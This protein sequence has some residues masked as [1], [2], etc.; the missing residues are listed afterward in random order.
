MRTIHLINDLTCVGG[1]AITVPQF[2]NALVDADL[3]VEL[4]SIARGPVDSSEFRFRYREFPSSNVLRQLNISGPLHDALRAA[5]RESLV[6]H[7]HGLWSM[8]SIYPT[9]VARRQK[10]I[11]TVMAPHGALAPFAFRWRWWRKAPFWWAVQKKALRSFDALHSTGPGETRDLRQ[12]GLKQP[13]IVVPNVVPIP[14]KWRD[15]P[16][17][18][19]PRRAMFLGRLHPIKG[20]DTL[21]KAW[22]LVQ[23]RFP[24]W[25]LELVGPEDLK[26]YRLLLSQL[27]GELG[28]QR[29]IF[30]GPALNG[31]RDAAYNRAD[32]FVLPSHSENFGL[33]VGEA[34][35]HGVPAIA[36]QGSPWQRLESQGCGWWVEHAENTIADALCEAMSHSD[37]ELRAKGARGREWVSREFSM[38]RVA[39]LTRDA[40]AWLLGGGAPPECVTL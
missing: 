24:D 29:L 19:R 22:R 8:S 10:D 11:R 32:L 14:D 35:A 12:L 37:P 34:L 28:V 27:A 18:A 5:A 17:D 15:P 20:L 31:D 23:D 13:I 6:M 30:S 26:G 1:P 2:C 38:P 4:F 3:D 21:I 40:Y 25:E 16:N 7:S 9:W 39:Q 33:V 36:C